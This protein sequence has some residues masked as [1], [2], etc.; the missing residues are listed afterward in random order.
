VLLF[1]LAVLTFNTILLLFEIGE[2]VVLFIVEFGTLAVVIEFVF[3]IFFIGEVMILLLE[4]PDVS[5]DEDEDE[6]VELELGLDADADAD[7]DGD[8][9]EELKTLLFELEVTLFVVEEILVNPDAD[10]EV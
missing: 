2:L 3:I 6:E 8:E 9:D 10:D 1:V 5:A 4:D 7:E